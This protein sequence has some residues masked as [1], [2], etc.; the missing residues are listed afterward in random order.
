MKDTLITL[1]PGN[2]YKE[3]IFYTLKQVS[4]QFKIGNPTEYSFPSHN[5][6]NTTYQQKDIWKLRLSG[7]LLKPGRASSRGNETS[8]HIQQLPVNIHNA[9]RMDKNKDG[10]EIKRTNG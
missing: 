5:G 9:S 3:T 8:T 7:H 1:G 6:I 4:Q 10:V 2:I